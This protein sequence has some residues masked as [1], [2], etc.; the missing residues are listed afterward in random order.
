M[1]LYLVTAKDHTWDEY[2]KFVIFANSP[3]HAL[4]LAVNE[5][6]VYDDESNF[7]DATV[8]EVIYP[9]EPF[10]LLGSFNAG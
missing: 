4:K 1:K 8:E 5:S 6:K 9:S 2:D 10:V 7:N 3:E